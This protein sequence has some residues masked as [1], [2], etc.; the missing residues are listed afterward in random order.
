M[1]S[2]VTDAEQTTSLWSLNQ[3]VVKAVVRDTENRLDS[4]FVDDEVCS[5]L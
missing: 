3:G 4:L 2:R 1:N 5:F